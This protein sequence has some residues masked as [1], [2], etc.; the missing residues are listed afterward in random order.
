M[1]VYFLKKHKSDPGKQAPQ[2][3]WILRRKEQEGCWE[4]TAAGEAVEVE[5]SG[6][7]VGCAAIKVALFCFLTALGILTLH[8]RSFLSILASA[9]PSYL[10]EDTW[11]YLLDCSGGSDPEPKA[12][13]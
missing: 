4:P 1:G 6:L 11:R 13:S 10:L 8:S 5:V 9:Y 3:N 12:C 7:S 2:D